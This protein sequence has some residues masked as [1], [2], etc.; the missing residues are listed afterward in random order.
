[1]RLVRDI[2]SATATV[3]LVLA[4][5]FA[6]M[7]L[8]GVGRP[9]D[10]AELIAPQDGITSVAVPAHEGQMHV[11]DQLIAPAGEATSIA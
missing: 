3:S 10:S 1:M 11:N 6:G 8:L 7:Y 9:D 5:I 2:A 4:A